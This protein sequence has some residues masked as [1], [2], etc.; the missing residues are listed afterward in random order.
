MSAFKKRLA[1]SVHYYPHL[2]HYQ[3]SAL[4]LGKAVF[5][6]VSDYSGC[7]EQQ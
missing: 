6:L 1:Q 2:N 4:T 5:F 3:V 7:S